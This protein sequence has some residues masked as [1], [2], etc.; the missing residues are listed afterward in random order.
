MFDIENQEYRGGDACARP[1]VRQLT[2]HAPEVTSKSWLAVSSPALATIAPSVSSTVSG[3]P[4]CT[5]I[6]Y[7][8]SSICIHM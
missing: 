2:S 8:N 1:E 7:I 6:Q 3:K 4:L 5:Y